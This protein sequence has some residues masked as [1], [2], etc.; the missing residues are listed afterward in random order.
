MYGHTQEKRISRKTQQ[1]W[2]FQSIKNWISRYRH[3]C[4]RKK[5]DV[6]THTGEADIS[7]NTPDLDVSICQ[8]WICRKILTFIEKPDVQTHTGEADISKK[9]KQTWIFLSVVVSRAEVASSARKMV[10][11]FVL[12]CC[13]Y[14]VDIHP[15]KKLVFHAGGGDSIFDIV[16]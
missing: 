8:N 11:V 5:A 7:K 15:V 4:R 14:S 6:R 3:C 16:K 12:V 1:A 10:C 13:Y 9:T 2:K